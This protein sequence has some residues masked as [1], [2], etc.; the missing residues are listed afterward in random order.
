M[1]RKD[2]PLLIMLIAGAVMCI[3]S[4]VQKF[5]ILAKLVSL[6]VVFLVFYILG[7]VLVW[8]LNRFDS[9]NEE[10]L[11]EEGEMIEKDGESTEEIQ[12]PENGQV[13]REQVKREQVRREQLE[14]EQFESEQD[15]DE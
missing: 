11:R 7:N 10:K 1:N 4:Y 15:E 3:I 14:S 12:Q 9:Q 2:L 8:T 6:F 5:T 13:K